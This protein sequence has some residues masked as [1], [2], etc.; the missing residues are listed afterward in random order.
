MLDKL[1][2]SKLYYKDGVSSSDD[3]FTTLNSYENEPES[4]CLAFQ[5]HL[6]SLLGCS[7]RFEKASRGRLGRTFKCVLGNGKVLFCK[8]HQQG[9]RYKQIIEKEYEK[10]FQ[11][12]G[13]SCPA[14]RSVFLRDLQSKRPRHVRR[15]QC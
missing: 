5:N 9:D 12:F 7:V 4:F 6:S 10:V 1:E 8:T 13:N 2:F 11:P 14:R 3:V 15:Q